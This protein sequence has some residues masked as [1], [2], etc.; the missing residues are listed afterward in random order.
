[1][2]AALGVSWLA[3]R[4]FSRDN[5]SDHQVVDVGPLDH[6][7]QGK[8]LTVP[9]RLLRLEHPAS[10]EDLLMTLLCYRHAILISHSDDPQA[11]PVILAGDRAMG[12][13]EERTR[14]A[15]AEGLAPVPKPLMA[16]LVEPIAEI[17][18]RSPDDVPRFEEEVTPLRAV[19][20]M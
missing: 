13:G 3:V 4:P 8:G 11:K 16:K 12:S 7:G 1:M 10:S 9:Q 5:A 18:G 20:K 19:W 2:H 15:A 14:D 6:L 17:S